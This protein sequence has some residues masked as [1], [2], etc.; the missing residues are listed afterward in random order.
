MARRT[1]IP[2]I[3]L[4][5][6][7][8]LSFAWGHRVTI[9]DLWGEVWKNRRFRD[10]LNAY[11]RADPLYQ[12]K[13]VFEYYCKDRMRGLMA[14]VKEPHRNANGEIVMIRKWFAVQV[15]GKS[16]VYL[17]AKDMT[18]EEVQSWLARVSGVARRYTLERSFATCVLNQLTA[19]K[20][21]TAGHVW[22]AASLDFAQ[23][24]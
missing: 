13:V 11:H 21:P 7:R 14:R 5:L 12:P 20:A 3:D 6:R 17:S 4:I 15:A 23:T 22:W 9:D 1:S 2:A 10:I 8:V 24:T 16:R 19:S 18:L